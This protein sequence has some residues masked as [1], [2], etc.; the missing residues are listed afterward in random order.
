M[1]RPRRPATWLG[2][3]YFGTMAIPITDGRDFTDADDRHAPKVAIVNETFARVYGG[4]RSLLG[5]RIGVSRAE[6]T[7]VGIARDAKYA[8][9]REPIAPVW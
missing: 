5:A 4:G 7:I 1:R 9:V 6:F 3:G 2:P 8:H